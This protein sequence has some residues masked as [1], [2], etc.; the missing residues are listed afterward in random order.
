MPNTPQV[1][2]HEIK[3]LKEKV[4]KLITTNSLQKQ[5]KTRGLKNQ[6]PQQ[7]KRSKNNDRGQSQRHYLSI[8]SLGSIRHSYN[9]Q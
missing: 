8:Q 7:Q 6:F 9:K 3:L 4:P 1:T 2:K 5:Q